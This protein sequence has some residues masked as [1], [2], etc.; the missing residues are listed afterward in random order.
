MEIALYV[1][2][3]VNGRVLLGENPNHQVPQ[4]IVGHFM[5]RAIQ[6]GNLILGRKTANMFFQYEAIRQTLAGTEI[7]VLS[8]DRQ[9]TEGVHHV[10]SPEEAVNHL[11]EKGFE[12]VFV[13]GGTETYQSFM[14]KGLLTD[15]FVNVLPIVSGSGG[16]FAYGEDLLLQ[17]KLNEYKTLVND[18]IQLHYKKV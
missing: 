18:I 12:K 16:D 13:G 15:L 7:L 17:F 1:S 6:S 9:L 11:R 3:S 8:R 5:E 10:A 2:V 4:E 14:E